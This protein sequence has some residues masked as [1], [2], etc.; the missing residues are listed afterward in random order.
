MR[1]TLVAVTALL[2]NS[3]IIPAHAGNTKLGL[4]LQTVSRDHPRACGE[5]WPF[6]PI[7]H[8]WSGSSPRMRGTPRVKIKLAHL[9]GIIPRACGEHMG[10][11]LHFDI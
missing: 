9:H 3:G 7:T 10:T 2:R 5:H 11:L 4:V 8:C 1:G 6:A